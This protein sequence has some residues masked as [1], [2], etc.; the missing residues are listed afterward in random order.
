MINWINV[1]T[2]TPSNPKILCWVFHKE[3][4]IINLAYFIDKKWIKVNGNELNISDDKTI[5]GKI[6]QEE[7]KPTHWLPTPSLHLVISTNAIDKAVANVYKIPVEN[8][9]SKRRFRK[10]V[11]EPRQT[12]MYLY[13]NLLKLSIKEITWSFHLSAHGTTING[14]KTIENLIATSQVYREKLKLI[15]NL[16][17]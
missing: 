10:K 7:I 8:L 5:Q 6:I 16:I 14:I 17:V 2:K 13:F 12:A 1:S 9:R 15:Q 3:E 11:V 4:K